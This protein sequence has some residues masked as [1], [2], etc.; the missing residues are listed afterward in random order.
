[1]SKGMIETLLVRLAEMKV[2]CE[3]IGLTATSDA[4]SGALRSWENYHSERTLMMLCSPLTACLA[5]ELK[6]RVCFILPSSSQGLYENPRKGW[7]KAIERFPQITDNVDEM[8]RCFALSRYPGA[9][10]HSLLIAEA[11]C[12]EL[13]KYI[14]VTDPV[15]GWDA[16]SKRLA[17][18]VKNGRNALPDGMSFSVVEQINQTVQSMKQAWRNKVNHEAGRLVVLD[19]LFTSAIAEEIITTVRGFMR[20]LAVGLPKE[21]L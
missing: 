5:N 2:E 17:E 8:A 18:L 16:T 7:E 19:P 10:F 21:A 20:R 13:G 14:G 1:M 12:I 9:V 6:R 3:K 11:G 15:K 4:I